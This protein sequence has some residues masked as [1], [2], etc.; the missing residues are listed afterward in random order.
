MYNQNQLTRQHID[1]QSL[2]QWASK[3]L[4]STSHLKSLIL[5][6]KDEITAEEFVIKIDVWTRLLTEETKK[7]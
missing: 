2:K 6:E 4:P 3:S 5:T 1:I 7:T